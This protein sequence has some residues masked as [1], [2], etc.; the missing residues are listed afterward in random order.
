[1]E[2]KER[3]GRR[4]RGGKKEKSTQHQLKTH[5]LIKIDLSRP[6]TG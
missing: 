5:D 1:M 6:G 4:G 2:W 3:E